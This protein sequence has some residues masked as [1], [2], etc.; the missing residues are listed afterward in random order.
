MSQ[1]PSYQQLANQFRPLFAQIAQGTVQRER[2]REL[3]YQP[4]AWLKA[5]KF[6]TLRIPVEQGGYGVSLPQLFT[7]LTELAEA[8]S[9][10]PQALRAHFAFVEDL[11]NQ[12]DTELRRR[13]FAR[14]VDGELVG[15]G[16]TEVGDVKVGEVITKVTPQSDGWWLNGEKFYSTGALYADWIDVY[17]QREDDGSDVIALVN[18]H[19]SGVERED[20]WDGFGQRLTGSGTTRFIQ[21]KVEQAHVYPFSQRFRYQTA[22]YQQVLLSALAGISKALTRDASAAVAA[23]QRVYSHGNANLVRHDAQVLQVVGQLASW[24]YAVEATVDRASQALEYAFTVHDS[25][26]E[27]LIQ[28]ANIAAEVEVAKAQVI[29]TEWVLRGASELFNALGASD[30]RLSKALDRHWRNARTLS[31]HNPVIYKIRNIGDW[32]VNKNTPTFIWQIGKGGD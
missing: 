7:L 9:N 18:V 21:A 32:H 29:A 25:G 4:L 14:F 6:G 5:A 31:S 10:L 19:Q 12:P 20:D 28:Q 15:S 27:E 8:D 26:D 13:W 1:H 16:W 24:S 3:P 11:L 23:R 17:A 22:F 30:T 2:D